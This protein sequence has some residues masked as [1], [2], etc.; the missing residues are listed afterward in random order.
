MDINWK[1]RYDDWNSAQSLRENMLVCF[2]LYAGYLAEQ[3]KITIPSGLAGEDAV[4]SLGIAVVNAFRSPS[5]PDVDGPF[6]CFCI[7]QLIQYFGV[8][9][10]E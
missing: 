3:G 1:P 8:K 2:G 4:A 6:D 7:D 5:T 10:N 9:E